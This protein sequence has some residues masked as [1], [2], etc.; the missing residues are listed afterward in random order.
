MNKK[1]LSKWNIYTVILDWGT[2]PLRVADAAIDI[3][4]AG[5]E[6]LIEND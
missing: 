1:F 3:L 5:Y 2:K 6:F 4:E